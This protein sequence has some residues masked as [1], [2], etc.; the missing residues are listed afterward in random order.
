MRQAWM[1]ILKDI[2]LR[3][4]DLMLAGGTIAAAEFQ[5]HLLHAFAGKF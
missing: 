2:S 5:D 1:S 4:I 3:Q